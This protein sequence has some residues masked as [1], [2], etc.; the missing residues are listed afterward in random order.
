[1]AITVQE[2]E[3]FDTNLVLTQAGSWLDLMKAVATATANLHDHALLPMTAAWSGAAGELAADNVAKMHG[4]MIEISPK[5]QQAADMLENFA[6]S[7][8]QA[9]K[10][11]ASTIKTMQQEFAAVGAFTGVAP[12]GTV[13]VAYDPLVFGGNSQTSQVA[14]SFE[15]EIKAILAEV[16]AM[17][18]AVAIE[19]TALKLPSASAP[20]RPAPSTPPASAPSPPGVTALG[21]RYLS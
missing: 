13:E 7:V 4:K 2:L 17:D 3:E 18:T 16:N 11:L 20:S 19:L 8:K 21:R 6:S 9:Q 10:A 15:G 5:L 14:A 1:M 12:D